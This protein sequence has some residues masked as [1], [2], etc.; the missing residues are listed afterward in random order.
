MSFDSIEP[1][2]VS[3]CDYSRSVKA[4]R[5]QRQ[6]RKT[7]LQGIMANIM[8][9]RDVPLTLTGHEVQGRR[10]VLQGIIANIM[11]SRDVPLTLTGHEVHV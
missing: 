5:L 4:E 1:L 6:G 10:T 2:S 9:S 3:Q 11:S 8:S 7:V